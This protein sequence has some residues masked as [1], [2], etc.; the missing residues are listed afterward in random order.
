VG[1]DAPASSAKTQERLGWH[2]TQTGLIADVEYP[3]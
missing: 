3:D 1:T 2:P